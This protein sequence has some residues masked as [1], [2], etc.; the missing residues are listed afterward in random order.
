M[1][2]GR[3]GTDYGPRI[4]AQLGHQPPALDGHANIAATNRHHAPDPQRTL[5]LLDDFA[6]SLAVTAGYVSQAQ[7]GVAP[8]G[9]LA[10]ASLKDTLTSLS[11]S[12]V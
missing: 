11:S 2:V 12:M 8:F 3:H 1:F 6:G 9:R 4:T 10:Y 5:K 7:L